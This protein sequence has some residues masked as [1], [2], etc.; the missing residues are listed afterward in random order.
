MNERQWS[1]LQNQFLA[2]SIAAAL[3]RAATYL[4]EATEADAALLGRQMRS[5]LI[6]LSA[7]Y[8]N[9]VDEADHV[10]NIQVLADQVSAG[11]GHFLRDGRL[12]FG[13]AQKALNLF[14]KYLWCADRIPPPPHCPF[15]SVIIAKLPGVHVAWTKIEDAGPYWELVKA[16]KAQAGG[17]PLPEWEL[18]VYDNT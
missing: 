7:S 18:R 1:F 11:C 2:T 10:Q 4:P 12:R 15:D 5:L 14:L 16:A 13:G 17:E 9:E 6:Q 8:V 3:Q